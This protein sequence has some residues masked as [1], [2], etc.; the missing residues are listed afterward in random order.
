LSAQARE[1]ELG[2]GDDERSV[3]HRPLEREHGEASSAGTIAAP[4]TSP[5]QILQMQQLAGNAAVASVLASPMQEETISNRFDF[6]ATIRRAPGQFVAAFQ[7]A[8]AGGESA[9]P[10][11]TEAEPPDLAD[12]VEPAEGQTVRIP[13]IDPQLPPA[14]F[15]DA[16]AS[17]I[18]F[19]PTVTQAAGDPA[20]AGEFGVTDASSF[21]LSGITVTPSAGKFQVQARLDNPI[22]FNV[23][24]G[25]GP[26][27]QKDIPSVTAAAI[28]KAN[29]PD[30]SGDLTP[31][32]SD[33]GGRPPR[34]EF[35]ARDL[36][37]VHE[38]FHA[39]DSQRFS[40]AG[41]NLEQ[42]RLNAATAAS[43]ADVQALLAQVPG[44]VRT[45][46]FAGMPYP[47]REE[48]AYGDGAAAYTARADAIF[49]KGQKDGYK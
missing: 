21:A 14:P 23:R 15:A 47:A 18:A 30:V 35:Y 29:Y 32:M 42:N 33:L 25:A 41:V 6:M 46:M 40:R 16:I 8:A 10:D 28:T 34:T 49:A 20:G 17:A 39:T 38:R 37:I 26:T 2:K 19:N 11:T 31:D 12:I 24:T 43:V 4:L 13:N 1:F 44:R 36:T 5:G 22:T 45:A 9:E 48:R 7:D 3:L 27:G